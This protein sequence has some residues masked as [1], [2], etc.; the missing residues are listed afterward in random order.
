MRVGPFGVSR[1]RAMPKSMTRGPVEES[2]TLAGLRSRCTIPAPWMA[3]SAVA[4]PTARPSRSEPGSGPLP[5]TA[6][7]RFGPSMYSVTMYGGSWSSSASI[8]GAVQ[9]RWTRRAA[10]TSRRNRARN[11]GSPASSRLTTFTA[12]RRPSGS[13]PR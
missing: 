1:A 6:F 3:A 13:A 7:S 10:V 12:T 5:R 9:N 2:R 4:T 8:T 11:A